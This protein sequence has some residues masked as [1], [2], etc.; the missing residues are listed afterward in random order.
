MVSV[1]VFCNHFKKHIMAYVTADQTGK[2]VAK[3][4]GQ[5]YI[6]IFGA[7][8]KLLSDWGANFESNIIK[9]LC[10]LM[11]I[12]KVRTSPYHAQTNRQV[13]WAHQMPM[14]MIGKLSRD[15]KM[16]WPRHLPELV[17]AYNSMRSAINISPIN[18]YF[19]RMRGM[20]KE[21]HW[22]LHCQVM[23]T[24]ARSLQGSTGTFHVW[25]WETEVILW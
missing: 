23:W 17:H 2:T 18:I 13:G 7:L 9:E 12:W 5:G 3:F 22:L 25:G 10:E 1:L 6:L 24:T 21:V 20:E 15:W 4:L 11:G 16:D 8:T 19:I 14:S